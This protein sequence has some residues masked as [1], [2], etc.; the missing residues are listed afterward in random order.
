MKQIVPYLHPARGLYQLPVTTTNEI[1]KAEATET[2]IL[3]SIMWEITSLEFGQCVL[4]LTKKDSEQELLD[5]IAT[6]LKDNVNFKIPVYLVRGEEDLLT[7][8]ES[9]KNY[10]DKIKAPEK[11][12][13]LLPKTAHE[14]NVPVLE[15]QYKIFKSIKTS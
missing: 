15:A 10:F 13:F 9:T 6:L 1:T 8:K 5:Q 12:Y 3:L 2:T 7:P 14:F 11:K 4:R